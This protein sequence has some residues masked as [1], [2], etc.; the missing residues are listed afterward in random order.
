MSA[1]CMA[2]S[3][4]F[5]KI[6]P[7]PPPK[8][9]L[10]FDR[11]TGL[12]WPVE[13]SAKGLDDEQTERYIADLNAR[14]HGGFDDWRVPTRV[15]LLTIVDDTRHSPT[16]DADAF[17]GTPSAW[18]RTA[19]P[20][21]ADPKTYA[22]FVLFGLGASGDGHRDGVGRVRAVRGPSR[23]SSASLRSGA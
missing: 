7:A 9:K 22:W 4:R 15:E 12:T 6:I 8:H 17:P 3:A 18:F 10:V 2:K 16:I 13:F 19:T 11:E 5:E 20:Y 23:Q 14:K 21:A 1:D